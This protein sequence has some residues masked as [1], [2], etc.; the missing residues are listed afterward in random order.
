MHKFIYAKKSEFISVICT[1]V[2]LILFFCH[3]AVIF[4]QHILPRACL[5]I[6]QPTAT[7]QFPRFELQI[8]LTLGVQR[9]QRVNS[10]W[11]SVTVSVRMLLLLLLLPLLVNICISLF[12]ALCFPTKF[13]THF[14]QAFSTAIPQNLRQL[15]QDLFFCSP[16]WHKFNDSQHVLRIDFGLIECLLFLNKSGGVWDVF[17]LHI[18]Y[19]A[20]FPTIYCLFCWLM[21]SDFSD[22]HCVELSA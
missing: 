4:T 10:F 19:V 8:Q 15:G 21:F 7:H 3:S 17:C 6:S 14:R 13:A 11:I 18:S 20:N 2:R 22:I 12:A 5:L 1:V 9:V 16:F